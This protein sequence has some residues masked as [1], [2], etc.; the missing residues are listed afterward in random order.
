MI[1]KGTLNNYL[2]LLYL[3]LFI[4]VNQGCEEAQPLP[5]N[6]DLTVTDLSTNSLTDSS[7]QITFTLNGSGDNYSISDNLGTIEEKSVGEGI[8]NYGN[9]L[10]NSEVQLKILDK[11]QDSCEFLSE[12][13]AHI[14]HNRNKC[15]VS[16]TSVV[17]FCPTDSTFGV[18]LSFSGEGSF[19][20]IT[21]DQFRLIS[22][23]SIEGSYYLGEYLNNS[24]LNFIVNSKLGSG[25]SD[26]VN[27]TSIDCNRVNDCS[28][29]IDSLY[30]IQITETKFELIVSF[31]GSGASYV[32]EDNQGNPPISG[33]APGEYLVGVYNNVNKDKILISVSDQSIDETCSV[34][35]NINTP[36]IQCTPPLISICDVALENIKT[37]C[38][39]DS[40]F[41]V[42]LSITGTGDTHQIFDDQ[43]S[44][45][46]LGL[47]PGTYKYGL[48]KIGTPV[49]LTVANFAIFGCFATTDILL[50]DC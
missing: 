37:N 24:E 1:Q 50:D 47:C 12:I 42:E 16:I 23:P 21:D 41:E 40:T 38:L 22:S 18:L 10:N 3:V 33:L 11:N 45:P 15:D 9:Y 25:C 39:S 5:V 17:S 44:S 32:V 26:E 31:S 35:K 36:E 2:I 7:F 43:G 8:Y 49:E 19:F 4:S 27:L 30:A 46:F 20:Y 13:L 14:T 29:Q 28:L 6:C 34:V 48:Y